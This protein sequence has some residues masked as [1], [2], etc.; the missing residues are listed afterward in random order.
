M[1]T[2]LPGPSAVVPLGSRSVR[3]VCRIRCGCAMWTLPL[4]P[5]DGATKRVRGVLD[6]LRVRYADFAAGAFGA[7]P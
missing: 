6:R 1:R 4:G 5:S 7:V 3:G 2:L